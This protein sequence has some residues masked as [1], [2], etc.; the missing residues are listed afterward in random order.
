MT[1]R[2]VIH[3][4]G[5][6]TVARMLERDDFEQR[7]RAQQPISLHE[8]LYPLAQAHD[9]VALAADIELGGT[10]QKFNLLVGREVQQAYGQAPQIC[11]TLPLLVGTDG[12]EKMSKSLDN[13]I[14]LTEPPEEMYGKVLSIPDTLIYPY[15]ALVTDVPV[16]ELPHYKTFAS[17]EPRNAK[18]ALAWRIVRMYHGEDA[19]STAREHFERTIIQKEVPDQIVEFRPTPQEDVH[20]ALPA[21]IHQAGLASST[22]EA[23]R[24]IQQQAVSIDGQKVTETRATIDL[25]ERTPFVLR[26]GKRRFA[27]IV[28]KR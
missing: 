1:F 5:T 4:A 16:D 25:E 21:L 22:S 6:S 7:Y 9:S 10:D 12:V 3:L 11:M 14:G 2:E 26:V 8:F 18:H 17:A 15:F 28:W 23:R 27:R 19:A 20:V 24:L 13:Y